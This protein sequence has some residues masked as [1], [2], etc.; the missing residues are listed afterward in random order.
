MLS[1]QFLT[2]LPMTILGFVFTS[3]LWLLML[4]G[5]VMMKFGVFGCGNRCGRA[6]FKNTDAAPDQ[7]KPYDEDDI[8]P[9][10]QSGF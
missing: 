1:F 10:G 2:I 5:L 4:V 6:K 9:D 7:N 8:V 3:K